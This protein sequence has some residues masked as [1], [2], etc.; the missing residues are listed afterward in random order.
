MT[1]EFTQ[2]LES[3]K[4][5]YK[6]FNELYKNRDNLTQK[7]NESGGLIGDGYSIDNYEIGNSAPKTVQRGRNDEDSKMLENLDSGKEG[8]KGDGLTSETAIKGA[9]LALEIGKGFS[10]TSGSEKEGWAQAGTWGLKGGALGMQVGGP[11]GAAIG[12]G[13]GTIAGVVDAFGD[14]TKRNTE[15]RK[16]TDLK[17]EAMFTKREL[18][19]SIQEDE[20]R[21]KA[22]TALRK[23]QLNYIN[24]DY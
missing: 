11:V 19:G 5:S 22:L 3:A 20:K 17:N 2:D 18:D 12:A 10:T 8:F 23:N 14:I 15:T 4:T 21:I 1:Y 16:Q 9:G 7:M 24:L 6:N 13:V